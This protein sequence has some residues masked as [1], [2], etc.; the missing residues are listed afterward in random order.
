VGTVEIEGRL[1]LPPSDL[2]ALGAPISGTIRQNLAL[3]QFSAETGLQLLPLT[4][5][6]TGPSSEGLLREWPVVNLGIEKNYGYAAQW[7]G[8][9]ALF[10]LLYLWFQIIRRF[11]RRPKD[12]TPDV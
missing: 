5:Q 12:P 2:Y 10:S 3:P 9:A 4:L 7:F 11:I 8:M 6:Q 1:A